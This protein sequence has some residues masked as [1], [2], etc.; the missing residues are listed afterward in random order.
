[1]IERI[2]TSLPGVFELRP[3]VFSDARGFFVETYHETQFLEL[4]IKEHF[5]QDNHSSSVRGTLRGFH[6]QLRRPQAKLCRVIEG[7]ALDVAVDIRLGSP[8]FGKWASVVLS[9]DAKNQIYIPP[10]FAHAFLALTDRV[11]LLYKCSD[12]YD[13][14]DQWGILWNDPDL[15]IP[16]DIE[17]PLLSQKDAKNP[18]LA[19]IARECL[20]QYPRP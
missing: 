3:S 14:E 8:Y 13:P 6:Y 7:K 20:P 12:F 17:T 19:Q 5:V 11:Q 4:G 10:G 15:S 2:E 9:A 1:M 16:W 18:K